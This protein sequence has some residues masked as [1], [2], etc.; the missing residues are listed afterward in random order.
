MPTIVTLGNV[1]TEDRVSG[2]TESKFLLYLPKNKKEIGSL[3][4]ADFSTEHLYDQSS[5][6]FGVNYSLVATIRKGNHAFIISDINDKNSETFIEPKE[7]FDIPYVQ[8]K[9][10][11]VENTIYQRST[12]ANNEDVYQSIVDNVNNFETIYQMPFDHANDDNFDL[13]V[14]DVGIENIL[15]WLETG[16]LET[17]FRELCKSTGE[18]PDSLIHKLNS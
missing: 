2:R 1:R 9:M 14:K 15:T 10:N 3:L 5:N 16:S 11:G 12:T 17:A 7:L 18:D 13:I 8:K 4:I 6:Y